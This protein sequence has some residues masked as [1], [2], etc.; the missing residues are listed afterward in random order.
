MS[1]SLTHQ[2]TQN[3]SLLLSLKKSQLQEILAAS[4]DAIALADDRGCYLDVNPAACELFGL[5]KQQLLDRSLSDFAEPGFDF[6]QVLLQFQQPE[7]GRRE[8]K[9]VRA[10]REIHLVEYTVQVNF[11]P[12][13]HL[14]VM[15]DI[16][17]CHQAESQV[18]ELTQQLQ[19]TQAR[20][21]ELSI[22]LATPTTSIAATTRAENQR[23]EEITRHIPG[24]IYQFLMRP[25]RTF[26]F[27]Y[28]SERM[29]EIY[30]VSPE[31]I[32]EDASN[33]FSF[34]H[35]DDLDRVNRSIVESAEHLTPWYCEHRVCFPDGRTLWL[36]GNSL[37]QREPDGSIVWH[38]YIYN[39]S[40]RKIAEIALAKSEEKFRSIIENLNDLVYI[41]NPD[42]TFEYVSPKFKEI[43]GFEVADLLNQN[44]AEWVHPEYLSICAS[45]LQRSL[46][47]E[48]VQDIEYRVLHQDGNY[49]WHSS[50]LS[51]L[52]D[53]NGQVISCLG[54]ARYIHDRKQFDSELYQSRELLRSILDNLPQAIFWKNTDSILLGCNQYFAEVFGCNSPEETIGKTDDDFWIN[55]EAAERHRSSD[56]QVMA[57]N[58]PL[59]KSIEITNNSDGSQ[60]WFEITKVPL[61]DRSGEVIGILSVLDDITDRKQAEAVLR[62]SQQQL[63][64]ALSAAQMGV[65]YS[66]MATRVITL[67]P[68]AEKIF[69]LE[70]GTFGGKMQ[71]FLDRLHPD[72]RE[73]VI[74]ALQR[75]IDGEEKYQIEYRIIFPD[76]SIH[77]IEAQG[78][79]LRDDR[80]NPTATIGVVRDISDRKEA[81][82]KLAASQAELMALFNA[83]QD[84]IFVMDAGGRYLKIAPSSAPL[85]YKPSEEIL[86]KTLHEVLPQ[87]RANLFL[88][89]IRQAIAGRCL[90]QLEYTLPVGDRLVWFDAIISPMSEDRV[91]CV[92]RDISDR[93]HQEQSLRLIVEG[94]AGKTGQE[95]FK[96]CVQYL[97]QALEVRYALIAEVVGEE[98]TMAKTLAFWAGDGFGDNLTYNLAGG[99]CD[100]VYTQANLCVYPNSLQS[101]FPESPVIVDLQTESYAGLPIVDAGG[102]SLGLLAVLDTKPIVKNLEILSAIL[103]IFATRAGAEI[104]RIAAES[105]VQRSEIQLR[106]QTE[107]LAKTIAKLQNTQTQLIQAEKMSSLG[108]LVAGIAHEINNPVSF[109]YG[110][111]Q[112][113]ADYASD[114]IKLIQLY[115]EHYP[116][117]PQAISDFIAQIDFEYLADDFYKLLQSMKIGATRISTIVKSLRTFSR[118][119]EA[120]IKEVDIH[121][122]LESTLTILQNRLHGSS[123]NSNISVVKN[124]GKLPLIECY[125]GLLNQVFLNIFMNAI[126]AIEEKRASLKSPEKLDY[127]G[128]ITIATSLLLPDRVSISIRDNGCGLSSEVQEKIFNPFFTTKPVGKG[129]GMGLATAYQ[130]VTKNHRGDLQCF[131]TPG[132][133][134]EFVIL[135]PLSTLTD[136]A[137]IEQSPSHR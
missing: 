125:G 23:L 75:A 97:A 58:R 77:W 9:I 41:I 51:A 112:P 53:E 16:T 98:K 57:S 129:T 137:G 76:G 54:V 61:H 126:D 46:Q 81:E 71:D 96:S 29:G 72:E 95:F 44:F 104:E 100:S 38:G 108:Q 33:V 83:M 130:I 18:R 26:E 113:A 89:T 31:K 94:T 127:F 25:D 15:R 120:E 37:P 111:L 34:I 122:N 133:G 55:R 114:L 42:A 11:L 128:K 102:N 101:L 22:D 103:K 91:V 7:T 131:S 88:N 48:K 78:D 106:Q 1:Q 105:A 10:D 64:L 82:I 39:I 86:G 90:T 32:Q 59:L 73:R 123:D 79:V 67:T 8:L 92:A 135:L 107:E 2:K 60:S 56:R 62:R 85:L 70:I 99:P 124:Y 45:A 17:R 12:D 13:C 36:L 5:E 19:K 28:A 68:E 47:G 43:V 20:L 110:N 132:E 4:L 87:D 115:Q 121:E 134:T 3:N 84:V 6:Q 21:N 66:D 49:Y 136:R 93:K 27:P 24:A 69:G 40:D 109:I 116:S 80:G 119:D 35:P 117:P 65:W 14:L 30:G 50:N 63:E 74:A 118:L 52:K